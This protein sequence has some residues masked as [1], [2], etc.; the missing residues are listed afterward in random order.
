M[1]HFSLQKKSSSEENMQALYSNLQL[2]IEILYMS[3][4]MQRFVIFIT[5]DALHVSGVLRPSSGA[6]ELYRQLI[7]K[8]CDL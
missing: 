8:A 6:Y 2:D 3:N 1:S 4:E 7:V 5:N